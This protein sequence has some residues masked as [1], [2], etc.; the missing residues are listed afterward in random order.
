MRAFFKRDQA[1]DLVIG[2]KIYI[3]SGELQT[4]VGNITNFSDGGITIQFKP[5]NQEG[6][7]DILEINRSNVVRYF[8]KGD[9]VRVTEGKYL[10]EI[11]LVVHVDEENVSQPRIKLERTDIEISLHTNYLKARNERDDDIKAVNLRRKKGG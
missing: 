7:E 6:F 3:I 10:S 4:V 2:D 1:A 5:T 8:E 9:R 11:G